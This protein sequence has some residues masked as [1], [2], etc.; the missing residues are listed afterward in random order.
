MTQFAFPS[1][2]HKDRAYVC[3]HSDALWDACFNARRAMRLGQ[4]CGWYPTYGD[5]LTQHGHV[6]AVLED[7]FHE[8][9]GSLA[10]WLMEHPEDLESASDAWPRRGRFAQKHLAWA[11]TVKKTDKRRYYSRSEMKV[12]SSD[13]KR[14][15]KRWEEVP[16]YADGSF[17]SSVRLLG[18]LEHGDLLDKYME[19]NDARTMWAEMFDQ[20]A[21][22]PHSYLG[23]ERWHE[24]GRNRKCWDAFRAVDG[25]ISAWRAT[26]E[27]RSMATNRLQSLLPQEE[28]ET[29][30][31]TA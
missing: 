1:R 3:G 26:A 13:N 19:L 30:A 22:M 6:C 2:F 25:L 21:Y 29:E 4:F 15:D 31:A 18:V 8:Y 5:G 9:L 11:A 12:S 10:A 17:E 28:P 14:H 24:E 20:Y 27:A 16:D 23:L 7:Q